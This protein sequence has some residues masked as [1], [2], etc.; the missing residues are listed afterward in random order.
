MDNFYKKYKRYPTRIKDN[1]KNIYPGINK[2]F[3]QLNN[4]LVQ[5]KKI[6]YKIK[7]PNTFADFIKEEYDVET[8]QFTRFEVN[9]KKIKEAVIEYYNKYKVLPTAND[10]F[11]NSKGQNVNFPGLY[12]TIKNTIRENRNSYY[13]GKKS[14]LEI[15]GEVYKE[16]GGKMNLK[17][18]YMKYLKPHLQDFIG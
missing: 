5:R 17:R 9:E 8:T 13:K 1:N 15:I 11:I 14:L 18:G 6:K 4:F 16:S 12:S 3:Y 10:R 2:T 7:L